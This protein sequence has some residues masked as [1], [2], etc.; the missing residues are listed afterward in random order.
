MREREEKRKEK[1]VKKFLVKNL[2]PVKAQL[3]QVN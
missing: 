2:F 3:F 1:V